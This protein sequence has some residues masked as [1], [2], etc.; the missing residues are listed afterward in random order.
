VRPCTQ[1]ANA[2]LTSTHPNMFEAA[3]AAAFDD[4]ARRCLFYRFGGDCYNY[5]M[6]AA[7]F[8]DLVVEAKLKP[9]DIVPLIPVLEGA[10]AV[11]SDWQGRKPVRGGAVV[12]AATQELHAA[13]IAVLRDAADA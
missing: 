4:L 12:V 7:G 13:A 5:A 2:V 8:V 3:S 10:G 9:Y 6:L 11:V 1:L